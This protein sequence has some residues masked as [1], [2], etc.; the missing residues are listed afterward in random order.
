MNADEKTPPSVARSTVASWFRWPHL[1]RRTLWG[2][3]VVAIVFAGGGTAAGFAV[4][5]GANGDGA[6]FQPSSPKLEVNVANGC[7]KS[8]A[9][10]QDVVNTFP[11]PPLVPA[12]PRAGLI[13]RYQPI[14]GLGPTPAGQ[15]LLATSKRL[16]TA[17]AQEL[18]T[19][20]RSLALTASVGAF[21]CPADF[22]EVAIIGFAYDGKADIGL[23]Y[24]TTGCQT[25]DNGRIGAFEGGNPSF[26]IGFVNLIERLSPPV[27][28]QIPNSGRHR[29]Q[30][31]AALAEVRR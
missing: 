22:G 21:H 6:W 4:A 24:R 30:D 10:F 5:G 14:Y 17:Q 31:A 1:R 11:G 26:Y 12:E 23:W 8:L 3:A 27:A 16:N 19:V 25:L 2:L 28:L 15:R 18:A 29:N 13:C 9:S 7:L 20:I